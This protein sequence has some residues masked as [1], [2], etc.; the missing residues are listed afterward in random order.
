MKRPAIFFD[1]DNTLIVGNEYLGDPAKV[2]LV[3]GAAAAVARARRLGYATVIV[4]NQSGVARGLFDET[5]VHAVNQRLD[6][7]LLADDP[8]A[9]IDRHEFCPFHPDAT[10]EKYKQESDLRKPAPG[11]LLKAADKLA[12]DLSRSWLVGDA[13]RDIE[14]GRNAGC[15]TILFTDPDLPPSPAAAAN[16]SIPADYTASTLADAIDF[17]EQCPE[18]PI[19]RITPAAEPSRTIDPTASD[20][21]IA[22]ALSCTAA[23]TARRPANDASPAEPL[24][25]ETPPT[26]ATETHQSATSPPPPAPAGPR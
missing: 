20:A 11:M 26:D 15:R 14:A 21:A 18:P 2:Q 1:R 3:T 7:L 6:Q 19:M 22:D 25:V 10:V 13:A 12:L 5:A 16:A 4:S 8:A 9:V 24:T 17:I 23:S